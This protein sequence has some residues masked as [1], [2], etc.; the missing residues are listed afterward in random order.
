M[1]LLDHPTILRALDWAWGQAAKG[2]PGQESA[3]QLAKRH[4][5][6]ATPLETRLKALIRS[7]KH[8]AAATG[9][10]TNVGGLALLPATL[11]ANL[12][13]SLFVQLRMVQAMAL[14][15]GHDLTDARVRAVCV[16][17]LCGSKA[18]EVAGACGVRLG[19]GAAERLLAQLGAETLARV[20]RLVGFRLLARAGESGLVGAGRLVP[21]VGGLV[22]AACDA[23]VTALIGKAAKAALAP[24]RPD[25]PNATDA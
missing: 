19:A 23:T 7:H 6:P 11:P 25:T 10:V 13:S 14:V 21:V 18:A 15:C 3:A 5:D 17:C 2:L 12:A 9:F 24:A 20:N 16:L 8:Q 1:A 4:M 22:G